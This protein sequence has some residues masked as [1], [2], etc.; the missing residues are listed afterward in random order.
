MPAGGTTTVV[1]ES[2]GGAEGAEECERDVI[3]RQQV[4]SWR[5]AKFRNI[6]LLGFAFMVLFS[7]FQTCGVIQ[8]IVLKSYFGDDASTLGYTSLAILYATLGVANWFS[9]FIVSLIGPKWGMIAGGLCY[10]LFIAIFLKPFY[11]TL[12]AGSVLVGVGAA[13]LWTAQGMFLTVNSDKQTM[14]RNSGLFWALFQSS[15]VIGNLFFFLYLRGQEDITDGSRMVIYTV[16]LSMSVVGVGIMLFFK[17]PV[18]G[19][20]AEESVLPV[21]DGNEPPPSRSPIQSIVDAFRMLKGKDMLLLSITFAYTGLHQTF[22]SGVYGTSLGYTT[23]FGIIRKSILGLAGVA[24]GVG[25]ITGGLAFGI[26]GKKT[27][28][29]GRDPIVLFGYLIH[30]IAFFLIFLNIP[31][32]APLRESTLQAYMTPNIYLGIFCCFLLGLGDASFNTQVYSLLGG[33]YRTNS[34]SAFALFKFVQSVC[35][36]LAF[37]YSSLLVL[38][39]QLLI[40]VV[41]GLLGTFCFS[42]VEWRHAADGVETKEV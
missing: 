28:R 29:Y 7:A 30:L 31:G 38:E 41:A 6:L 3:I 20:I 33:I 18:V 14:A 19:H 5:D 15:Y 35:A 39:F 9:P 1:R 11:G 25:Q 12:Y 22:F 4:S 34:A 27:I 10:S 2:G 26:L 21:R 36:A 8:T 23:D 13:V 42:F 24:I 17:Y 16:L 40:L 37:A 32:D